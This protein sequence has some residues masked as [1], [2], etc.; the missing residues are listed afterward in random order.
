MS[1]WKLNH[2]FYREGKRYA[3]YHGAVAIS[4]CQLDSCEPPKETPQQC[5]F[6]LANKALLDEIEG[7]IDMNHSHHSLNAINNIICRER[8]NA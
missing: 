6:Q 4:H 7:T 8:G 2:V 1:E 3:V 5:L